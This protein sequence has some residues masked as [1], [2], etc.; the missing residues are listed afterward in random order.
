M[1]TILE[2]KN[3]EFGDNPVISDRKRDHES[4][5]M[6]ISEMFSEHFTWCLGNSI[7]EFQIFYNFWEQK[8]TNMNTFGIHEFR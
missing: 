2:Q 1:E 4:N 8:I 5:E 3:N 6:V 7:R